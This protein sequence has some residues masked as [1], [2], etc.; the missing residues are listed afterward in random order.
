MSNLEQPTRTAPRTSSSFVLVVALIPFLPALFVFW[1]LF[2][3]CGPT[4][5][6]PGFSEAKFASLREGMSA[7]EVEAILGRPL[8]K[9]PQADGGM[10]WTYSDRDDDT[11]DFEMRWVYFKSGEIR[12]VVKMYWDD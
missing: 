3:R 11:C 2:L 5:Y 6:A 12:R 8:Q 1:F 4:Y 9:V 7:D 10:L